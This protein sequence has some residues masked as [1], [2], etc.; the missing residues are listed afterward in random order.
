VVESN[1][2]VYSSKMNFSQLMASVIE[3]LF[4]DGQPENLVS[5][6]GK[7]F[8]QAMTDIQNAVPCYRYGNTDFFPQCST[9]FNCGLTVLPQPMGQ[10]LRVCTIGKQQASGAQAAG[11]QI[12]DTA[13]QAPLISLVSG[14]LVTQPT[15]G[16]LVA[17][18]ADGIYTLTVK[19][20]NSLMALY[21]ANS[22]QYWQ[23][24]ITYTDTSGN[25]QTVQPAALIHVS[26]SATSGSLTIDIKGGTNVT[27]AI[28]PFNIPQSDGNISVE[29]SIVSG[30]SG[31]SDDDWCSKV[32]YEQ[33]E[34]AHIERYVRAC[35]NCK[36]SS[37]WN[38][39][40]AFVAQIFG[41]WRVKRVYSPP[42][43]L[44][45]EGL[46]PLPPGFHYP[47]TST[48]AGGRS[49]GGVYAIKHGRIYIAP[50]IESTESVIIEWNG[51]KTNWAQTDLVTDDPKFIEAVR[52]LV[53]IQH[54]MHYEDNDK[55]LKDFKTKYYGG[56][57]EDGTVIPGVQRELVVACRD[58]I[59][60]RRA[61]EV[62]SNDGDAAGGIG[63]TTGET[64]STGTYYNTVQSYTA[65]CPSGQT[66]SSVTISTAAGRF[67]S[68]LSQADA[69]AQALAA[70]TTAAT[71]ALVC[72]PGA[73]YLNSQQSFTAQCPAAS[74]T[75]PAAQGTPITI[76]VPAGQYKSVISQ[77][78]A[79]A[80]ALNAATTQAMSQL[81]CTYYNAPQTATVTC[82]N[83]ST[84][85]VTIAAGQFTSTSS[86]ADADQQALAAAQAQATAACSSGGGAIT[87]G[88]TAQTVQYSFN[89]TTTCGI[90]TT[91]NGGIFVPANTFFGQCTPATQSAVQ[92]A[93]NQQAINSAKAR[94][95]ALQSYY[96]R[97]YE[98]QCFGRFH[99]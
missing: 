79:D 37:L 36:Q 59:R 91:I 89:I 61:V 33:V 12:I 10:V 68:T 63:I 40:N 2:L 60:V 98:L 46:P 18:T 44:G 75:T 27:Y 87:I 1:N 77:A 17:I 48:D 88:N 39:A 57:S 70:A 5:Q 6:H 82:A 94:F 7:F 3:D 11:T 71:A 52:L 23:T 93:L 43:D 83:N 29:I 49:R 53:G 95:P 58:K 16:T 14:K 45:L 80:A 32:Y 13:V 24:Q 90:S 8:V 30:A 47:Q 38:V 97:L 22:P 19:Q 50:W 54:Y 21:P 9:Y 69:D 96:Q 28:T 4:A 84:Q 73:G 55:R 35:N 15:T 34:Y 62:G 64:N 81:V 74:G 76:T 41:N 85:T 66:G 86:Q 51:V 31:T 99:P 65:Q 78:L 72:T 42:T 92:A 26:D 56:R 20:V 67:S 25:I